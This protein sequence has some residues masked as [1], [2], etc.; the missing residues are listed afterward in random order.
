[1]ATILMAG[2]SLVVGDH[3]HIQT[4][5]AMILPKGTAHITDVGMVGSLNSSLG[6]DL[7]SVIPRWRD[8]KVTT[9]QVDNRQPWQ[10]NAV[11][12]KC[13]NQ[14]ASRIETIRLVKD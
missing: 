4:N 5:D 7:T 6:V 13:Q 2:A 8:G 11:V 10:L 9:N 12:V 14:L 3:W 1:M